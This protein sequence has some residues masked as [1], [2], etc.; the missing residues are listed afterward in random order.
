LRFEA[1]PQLRQS[2]L[3]ID[4]A[5]NS[6]LTITNLQLA[7]IGIY[8]VLASDTA[9]SASFR[10]APASLTGPIALTSQP[11]D[12]SVRL[13]TNA[14]FTVS[15]TGS[16]LN[17]Q[18]QFNGTNLAGATNSSLALTNIQL[19][20]EG[21]YS[22]TIS[23]SFGLV[24]VGVARLVVLVNPVLTQTPPGQ[25]TVV[26]GETVSYSVSIT[27]HPQPFNYQL[28]R[29]SV[30][31]TN[32]LLSASNCTFTL[33][34]VQTNQAG[35]YRIVVTNLASVGTF[36]NSIT[37]LNV[38]ADSDG[39]HIPDY[40][41]SLYGLN[42]NDPSDGNTDPDG[43]GMTN[44]QEYMA[45][46]DPTNALSFL[47][48]DVLSSGYPTDGAVMRFLAASNK[49]YTVQFRSVADNGAWNRLADVPSAPTNRLIQI[50]DPTLAGSNSGR[51]YR[52]A[53]PLIPLSVGH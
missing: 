50:P 28:R 6:I 7:D 49:T 40:W 5:T 31:L 1:P 44:W 9:S 29:G 30:I 39:D 35:V 43:D 26:A 37:T 23:N 22:A 42:P 16:A 48:I 33:T 11:Q 45:G 27:G 21:N 47:R 18:W 19:T 34:N 36:A 10:S 25:I 38:L 24:P 46:T 8:T 17:Y 12:K 51:F 32:I 14:T 4:G 13:G 41:E 15:A 52:L 3:A 53:T 20:D 2:A